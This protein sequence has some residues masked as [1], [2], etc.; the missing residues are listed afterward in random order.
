MVRLEVRTQRRAVSWLVLGMFAPLAMAWAQ[1]VPV[2]RTPA[3]AL[4]NQQERERVLRE[5]QE[6]RPDVR[7][8]RAH[9]TVLERLPAV[10]ESPCFPIWEIELNGEDAD[11]FRWALKAAD[12]NDDPATG[13]CLGTAGINLV[14]KRVQNAI[15]ARGY[16]TTRV[17]AAPQDLSTGTLALSVVAGRI[18]SI[19]FVNGAH[20]RATVWNAVPAKA[21][22]LLNLRDIEQAL[23]NFQRIPTV[24]A[25]IQAVPAEGN[26]AR[27]GDSDLVISWQQRSVARNALSLDD[28]G[29]QATG[30][31]QAGITV[32]LD[33]LTG[34][35]ELF[36]A[37]YGRGV[38]NDSG[39][40]TE[41]WTA[42]WDVPI[43]YWLL[44]TT[45]SSY[46]YHQAVVGPYETY[47]YSGSSRN[48]ELRA[49][50]LLF[51]NATTKF[52]AYGR[53]W[54]KD[55]DNFINDVEVQV[56]R[57]QTAGWE[58]G[59]THK[60]FLGKA[61][62]EAN[63]AYRR[64]TGA[65]GSLAAP[66]EAFGEGTSRM[67][68]I[69]ADSQLTAPIEWG[70]QP[71]RYRA[72]WRAQ[73][74]RTPL[75]PQDRFA[76]GSRYTVRGFD[77]EVSL[78][79][80]RGWL[81]RNELGLELGGGQEVYV[82]ADY[83]HVGGPSTAWQLGDHLAG[84]AIGLRGGWNDLSWDAFVGAPLVKPASYP[85]AFTAFGFSLGAS[86]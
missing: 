65:W 81:L 44:G 51:R 79:G 57:R 53:G 68:V 6:Q 43:G 2:E 71:L 55:S 37:N 9:D 78:T 22:D 25:E 73:W 45:V 18:R 15:V 67:K 26:D 34:A 20:S 4:L 5:Q 38:F 3:Q 61:T 77:G 54:W 12:P 59:V 85:T 27:P 1:P 84:M 58:L 35:N 30:K 10:D 40:G 21:G 72:S 8:E 42:H 52:G 75:T 63:A 11:R 49:A 62:L 64:G 17:L 80:E 7:L 33:N 76:I 86:F 69:T 70:N 46:D 74:N 14:L 39:R 36:Y 48:A 41:S 50:R 66:E 56:Q 16:I 24:A 19:R 23:E 83:G 28:S 47:V 29:S 31:L 60:L 32:S 13:R 82:G